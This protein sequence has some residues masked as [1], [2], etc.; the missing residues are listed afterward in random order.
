MHGRLHK[1][2]LRKF[3][4]SNILRT[5][6]HRWRWVQEAIVEGGC[7]GEKGIKLCS[8]H[9][10]NFSRGSLYAASSVCV[11]PKDITYKETLQY[12]WRHLGSLLWGMLVTV[13]IK[14]DRHVALTS[15][16][17]RFQ[18]NGT[19]VIRCNNISFSYLL[20]KV[21]GCKVGKRRGETWLLVSTQ[22]FQPKFS[23]GYFWLEFLLPPTLLINV[24]G[25]SYCTAN[26]CENFQCNSIWKSLLFLFLNFF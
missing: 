18:I 14:W 21:S 15:F 8:S 9:P 11:R 17:N 10:H 7:K 26:L 16:D 22:K 3:P 12:L 20:V 25:E 6:T 1:L 24:E 19:L 23:K 4:A 13:T 2:I 5:L